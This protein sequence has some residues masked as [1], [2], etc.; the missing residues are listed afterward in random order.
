MTGLNPLFYLHTQVG[1][2]VGQ[3]PD[4]PSVNPS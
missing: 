2:L 3:V 4:L 1:Q